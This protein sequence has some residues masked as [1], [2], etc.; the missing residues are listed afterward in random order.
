M[1]RAISAKR[2]AQGI[3]EGGIL[4]V[5]TF[6]LVLSEASRGTELSGRPIPAKDRGDIP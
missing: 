3:K 1:L 4:F 6:R 5:K 2:A